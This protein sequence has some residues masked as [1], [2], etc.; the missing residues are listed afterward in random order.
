MADILNAWVVRSSSDADRVSPIGSCWG[1]NPFSIEEMRNK[2][3]ELGGAYTSVSSVRMEHGSDGYT[4]TVIFQTN[5]GEL[6][7]SGKDFK[8]TFNLRAPGRI[9]IK[10]N[11]FVVEKQ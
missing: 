3:N 4:S 7:L 6:R 8:T 11:L 1:G 2:A 9:A 5:R 10:S